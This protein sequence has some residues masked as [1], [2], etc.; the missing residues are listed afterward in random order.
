M[1]SEN[2]VSAI[3]RTIIRFDI[4]LQFGVIPQF[5]GQTL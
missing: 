1:Q 3:Q 5:D 4:R 2:G